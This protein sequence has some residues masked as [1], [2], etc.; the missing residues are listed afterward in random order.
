MSEVKY[1]YRV[2]ILRGSGSV[3]V[4]DYDSVASIANDLEELVGEYPH[5]VISKQRI[6]VKDDDENE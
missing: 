1:R 3:W 6:V 5:L 4:E 2:T